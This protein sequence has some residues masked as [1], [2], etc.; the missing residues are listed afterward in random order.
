MGINVHDPI[1]DIKITESVCGFVAICMTLLR[2][3]IRRDR[4]WWDDA[5]ALFSLLNLF[6]QFGAVFMHVE[7]PSDL[8]RLNRIAAYYLMAVTFYTWLAGAFVAAVCFLLSQLFWTCEGI[9]GWKNKASP[10]CPLPK[11]VAN[12]SAHQYVYPDILADLSLI[13]L[14]LRLIRG[15]KDRRLRWRLIFIFSTSIAT[16]IVS[17]VHASYIISRGGIPVVISAL[18]ED[19]ISL[20]VANLPVVAAAWIRRLSGD[21]SNG[22]GEGQRWS[23]FKFKTRTMPPSSAGGAGTALFTTAA[24]ASV[25]ANAGTETELTS[26]SLEQSKGTMSIGI[27]GYSLGTVGADE[28]FANNGTKSV[29]GAA[30][31]DD[32]RREDNGGVVRIDVLPYPR[33][34]PPRP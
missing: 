22:D 5:W 15:I 10:Q 4:Y 29:D 2:L 31:K 13:L 12:M 7:H 30:E 17:L 27:G 8:S 33:E 14:P 32:V 26:T 9:H 16:T 21:R 34:Q 3:W 18:V 19:C 6:V 20:T 25:G 11:Q 1:V 28:L 24:G 23:S